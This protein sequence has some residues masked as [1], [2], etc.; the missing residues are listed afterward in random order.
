MDYRNMMFYK[1]PEM[2]T[3]KGRFHYVR[4]T[5]ENADGSVFPAVIAWIC[6]IQM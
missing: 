1:C 3:L 4:Y 6:A 2:Y 5:R